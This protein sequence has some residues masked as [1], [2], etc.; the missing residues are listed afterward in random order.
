LNYLLFFFPKFLNKPPDEDF[1]VLEPEK[2]P[3]FGIAKLFLLVY[4]LKK[5]H[6]LLLNPD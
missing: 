2:I 5:L 1:L 6:G 4:H 3:D